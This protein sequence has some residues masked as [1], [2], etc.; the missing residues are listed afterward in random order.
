MSEE[1]GGGG[2]GHGGP[3]WLLTYC[4]LITLLVAFFVMM[5]SM[6][7]I[8]VDKAKKGM[9]GF[10]QPFGGGGESLLESGTSP[11][12]THYKSTTERL[13]DLSEGGGSP[14]ED[15]GDEGKAPVEKFNDS[16]TMFRYIA[17]FINESGMSKFLD[18]EDVKVGCKI[19]IPVDD[20]FEKDTSVI[21]KDSQ[22]IFAK[23]GAIL[24]IV[25]GRIVVDTNMEVSGKKNKK[26]EKEIDLSVER[27]AAFCNYLVLKEEVSPQRIAISGYHA[28]DGG[29]RNT[30]TVIIF[31]K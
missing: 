25:N 27:A 8:N 17:G 28:A 20:C 18:V 29:D 15:E 31:K 3:V 26:L 10:E 13:V 24:R 19:K 22:R 5:I 12:E 1:E 30:I 4:D 11:I 6:S 9:A 14:F 7:T 21:K 23:L 16:A 2:G